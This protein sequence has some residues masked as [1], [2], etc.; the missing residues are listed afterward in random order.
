MSGFCSSS[1]AGVG[2]WAAA[3][4]EGAGA[5]TSGAESPST[6]ARMAPLLVLSSWTTQTEDTETDAG[7]G[8][9]PGGWPSSSARGSFE[10]SRRIARSLESPSGVKPDISRLSGDRNCRFINQ[11]ISIPNDGLS[12]LPYSPTPLVAALP[13]GRYSPTDTHRLLRDM[14]IV[15]GT[16]MDQRRAGAKPQPFSTSAGLSSSAARFFRALFL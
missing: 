10:D 6:D 8:G 16:D 11:L 5:L 3:A 2:A 15:R 1:S 13:L 12:S 14:S 4:K 9:S 7:G